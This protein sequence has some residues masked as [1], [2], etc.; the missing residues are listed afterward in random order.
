MF[1]PVQDHPLFDQMQ[2]HTDQVPNMTTDGNKVAATEND[3]TAA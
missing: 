2:Q 1:A 3:W